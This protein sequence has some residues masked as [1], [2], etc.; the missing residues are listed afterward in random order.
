[1]SWPYQAS[2]ACAATAR[3]ACT[4]GAAK[5]LSRA[6]QPYV[7]CVCSSQ[8]P[9]VKV[10]CTHPAPP[11]PCP[12]PGVQVYVLGGRMLRM[13]WRNPVMLVSESAQYAFMAIFVGLV[14]L[15]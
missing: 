11:P 7:R 6:R 8:R 15:Q 2:N 3:R 14:Y 13:W 9:F 4:A 1:M 10:L 12:P 5:L